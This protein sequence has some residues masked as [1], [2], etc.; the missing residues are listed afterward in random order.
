[1]RL[2]AFLIISLG[3]FLNNY[4]VDDLL[5]GFF[6]QMGTRLIYEGKR[7]AYVYVKYFFRYS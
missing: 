2:G 7:E 1:M 5:I 3:T 6:K 4:L